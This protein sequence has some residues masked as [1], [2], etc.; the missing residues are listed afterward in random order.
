[1]EKHYEEQHLSNEIPSGSTSEPALS[2]RSKDNKVPLADSESPP[3]P[4]ATGVRF[5][6][7]P[8]DRRPERSSEPIDIDEVDITFPL[9]EPLKPPPLRRKDCF[10]LPQSTLSPSYLLA[11]TNRFSID[12]IR[13]IE[14]NSGTFNLF[15]YGGLMF[16]SVLRAIA[17]KSIKGIYSPL[18]QRRLF[19]SSIDWAK[20]DTSI[21]SAAECMTPALLKGFDRWRASRLEWAVLQDSRMTRKILRDRARKGYL[22]IE[23][24]PPGEVVGFLILGLTDEALRYCDILFSSDRRTL[25]KPGSLGDLNEEESKIPDPSERPLQRQNVTVDVELVNGE[26]RPTEALTYVWSHG[27]EDL[28]GVWS[29]EKFVQGSMMSQLLGKDT[30]WRT[31][32]QALATIMKTSY[33]L[34]GDC[35]CSAITTGNIEELTYL[36]ENHYDPNGP[37][38]EYG[39]PLQAA[40][41]MGNES[42]VRLLL[43]YGANVNATGGRYQTP[44]IAATVGSRKNMTRLLLKEKAD[45]FAD[46]G[47]YINALYQAVGHSDWAIAEMLLE[48]GAW[49]TENYREILDLAQERNDTDILE[50]LAQYD[51]RSQYR[52]AMP[53]SGR[54]QISKGGE[55][56]NEDWQLVKT[57]QNVLTAVVKKVLVLQTKS[58]S[59]R[60]RKLVAVIKAA[61][62]A[63]APPKIL[64]FIRPA[65]EPIAA[66]IK[67][68]KDADKQ[69]DMESGDAIEDTSREEEDSP[70]HTDESRSERNERRLNASAVD[71]ISHSSPRTYSSNYSPG[72]GPL[73]NNTANGRCPA[74]DAKPSRCSPQVRWQDLTGSKSRSSGRDLY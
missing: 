35:L 34:V 66:L 31:E 71:N 15:V 19:P 18:H 58:G 1:M 26:I 49:L 48:R 61:L 36:L 65:M 7:L 11:G 21:K 59:W 73:Q 74:A 9:P 45:I 53:G 39:Y 60:G 41:S 67:V 44:L 22:P 13:A 17:A 37:C 28:R 25:T 32:E 8:T 29:P 23:P 56:G 63:G 51:W 40:V 27:T 20:A 46:G 3:E 14:R 38:R 69:N 52:R 43:D 50:L 4:P 72:D 62:D 70:C 10:P 47:I 68:L 2:L 12:E 6:A 64:D 33:A 16:P 55:G 24:E 5:S 30:A 57:S 54:L 42:M